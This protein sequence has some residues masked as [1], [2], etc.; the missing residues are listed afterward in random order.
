MKFLIFMKKP[1]RCPK[2]WTC[3]KPFLFLGRHCPSI[4]FFK[5]YNDEYG[6][7]VGDIVLK[8]IA[9]TL[10]KSITPSD[11]AARYGGEEYVVLLP[12]KTKDRALMIA[13][14][15]R[16]QIER[17]KLSLRRLETRVTASLGVAA[18]PEDGRTKEEIL[19][20][21]DKCLYQAKN[22]GRNRVCGVI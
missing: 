3:S 12:G 1:R 17:N 11:L 19:W 16:W 7:V 10:L 18:F 6:H 5:R 4:F 14:D 8:N 22:L 13:E 21:A 15:I 20:A 2:A 9:A